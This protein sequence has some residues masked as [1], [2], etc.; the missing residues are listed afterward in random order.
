M[1]EC[2]LYHIKT[3]EGKGEPMHGL[4]PPL[5]DLEVKS[6]SVQLGLELFVE[7]NYLLVRLV[8]DS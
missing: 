2:T 7:I 8:N 5:V 3:R 4:P 1:T 6:V